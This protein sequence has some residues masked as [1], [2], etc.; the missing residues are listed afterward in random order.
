MKRKK[1]FP[2]KSDDADRASMRF[3]K[4]YY[5]DLLD[6]GVHP[7]TLAE[8]NGWTHLMKHSECVHA[9]WRVECL[10]F[11]QMVKLEHIV[12]EYIPLSNDDDS[13][14]KTL[15]ARLK[16]IKK[17]LATLGYSEKWLAYE[18]MTMK[19]LEQQIAQYERKEDLNTEHYRYATFKRAINSIETFKDAQINHLIILM[20]EDADKTMAG[21]ALV[22][23]LRKKHLT[24][25]Q[26]MR[27]EKALTGFGDWTHNV[28]K[29]IKK[30][31]E[32]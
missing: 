17:H 10:D 13:L 19:Q 4:T 5:S 30:Q 24:Q 8:K 25:T 26:F 15:T 16:T 22:E 21:S 7:T 29:R 11:N 28:I 20:T 31:H 2:L 12:S 23:L 3:V 6:A 18:M 27:V 14:L 1:S 32:E 9:G